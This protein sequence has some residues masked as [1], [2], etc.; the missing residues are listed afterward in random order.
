MTSWEDEPGEG[1]AIHVDPALRRAVIT[2]AP[3]VP[4]FNP[5]MATIDTLLSHPDFKPEFAVISDWRGATGAPE[6][7]FVEAFL[8]FCQSVRRARRLSGRWAIVVSPDA[9]AGFGAGR[10]M[11]AQPTEQGLDHRLFKSLDEALAWAT[12]NP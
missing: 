11:D 9:D 2:W 8:V 5:W 7:A 12:N 4:V 3:G 1:A 10:V 6:T